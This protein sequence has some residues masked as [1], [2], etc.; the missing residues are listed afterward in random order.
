MD[1]GL[2]DQHNGIADVLAGKEA[3][4]FFRA[5][6]EE[7]EA[8]LRGATREETHC[9]VTEIADAIEENDGLLGAHNSS[10]AA[11]AE[12]DGEL[13]QAESLIGIERLAHRDVAPFGEEAEIVSD[14]H[15]ETHERL[16][17]ARGA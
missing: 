13:L 17:V 7:A 9:I 10:L 16:V 2:V 4:G 6:G 3:L 11:K 14:G 1:A 15:T 8:P 12:A 5:K